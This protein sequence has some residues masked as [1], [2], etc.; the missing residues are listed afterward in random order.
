MVNYSSLDLIIQ[1][2]SDLKLLPFICWLCT[3]TAS[4]YMKMWAFHPSNRGNILGSQ[5]YFGQTVVPDSNL[6][7][8]A[9]IWDCTD[10]DWCR[11]PK[12]SG[13]ASMVIKGIWINTCYPGAKAVA[14]INPDAVQPQAAF[15]ETTTTLEASLSAAHPI[16][17]SDGTAATAA[18]SPASNV[19]DNVPAAANPENTTSVAA[20]AEISATSVAPDEAV[21][22]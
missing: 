16:E 19:S 2:I 13:D 20:P 3:I 18:L 4:R 9:G 15:N 14:T 8:Y 10:D 17:T 5:E 6:R 7:M 11:E 1:R 12:F 21:K 22:P